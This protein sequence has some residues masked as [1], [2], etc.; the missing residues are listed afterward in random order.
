MGLDNGI[1][2]KKM[3]K[4]QIESIPSFLN[5]DKTNVNNIEVTYWRKCWGIRREIIFTLNM[6][7]DASVKKL[8]REDIHEIIEILYDFLSE[9][10]WEESGDSIW[11][12]YE[13]EK[14]LVEDIMNL[15]WLYYFMKDNDNI[16]VEFY[17]SY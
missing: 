17:D 4:E 7:N 9:E 1:I 2:I 10:T 5:I 13:I 11:E 3:T 6:D 14:K 8:N 15:S 16:E 12:Y